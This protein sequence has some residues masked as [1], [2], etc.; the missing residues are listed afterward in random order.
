MPQL[1][2]IYD[3][4]DAAAIAPW[5]D[6]LFNHCEVIHPVFTGD[7]AEVREYH[8]EN[9]KTCQAALIFYGAGNEVWL[10][11]KLRELQKS[12][13]Y[14]R[15]GGT[16]LIGVCLIAPRTPDKERFR[17]HEAMRLEQW[18]GVSPDELEPFITRLTQAAD[19]HA[20]DDH[21]ASA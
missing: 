21:E 13:G 11:R 6:F 20:S 15:T 12:A 4:R 10:R 19:A 1:Y 5:A 17:T 7:E 9:L 3:Q 2:L 8:E 16:P 18:N 14:G